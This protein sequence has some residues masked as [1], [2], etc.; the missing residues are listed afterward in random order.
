M[1]H[2]ALDDVRAGLTEGLRA[3]GLIEGRDYRIVDRNANG[4]M[5][6]TA[7]IAAD[8]EAQSPDVIVPITTPMAQAVRAR[9]RRPIV[10]GAVTDPVGAGVVSDLRGTPG[11]TGTSDAWPYRQQ[12]E[13]IR[14][15]QPNA[16][17]LAV[18]YNPGE[19]ASQYGIRQIRAHAGALNF[20]LVEIPVASS[21]EMA[22][23]ARL[24]TRRADALFLS[25]DN[26]VISAVPS[27]FA[28]AVQAR[29]PLYVGDS[30][31]VE[32]GGVAAVSV[33]YRA[34]G[35]ETGRLV[36]QVLR[37]RDRIPVSVATD[38]EVFVNTRAAQLMGIQIPQP[39]LAHAK[40]VFTTIAD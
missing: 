17:R 2:P 10:F 14:Q 33:G 40:R 5:E 15:I 3:E 16:R 38:T 25:S 11:I 36:A 19:A 21:N 32:K 39:V 13:L 31:T 4:Q 6:L 24:A 22:S 18:L 12:L 28:A 7:S 26:T 34:L 8:L 23:A 29:V 27:A 35:R 1:S 30:G 20:T 9:T 37:G